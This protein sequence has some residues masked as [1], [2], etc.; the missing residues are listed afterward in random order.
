MLDV[1]ACK[2][3]IDGVQDALVGMAKQQ[4]IEV[5]IPPDHP[6]VRAILLF[7]DEQLWANLR[8]SARPPEDPGPDRL[9]L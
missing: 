4:R 2:V 8:A 9:D 1:Y 7:N 6:L 5:E 3:I